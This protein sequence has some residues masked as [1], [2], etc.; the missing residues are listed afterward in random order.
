[1]SS[2]KIKIAMQAGIQG[3]NLG[4]PHSYQCPLKPTML[5]IIR[6][7]ACGLIMILNIRGGAPSYFE[8][9]AN[10][11]TSAVGPYTEGMI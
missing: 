2:I 11:F 6:I 5:E 4:T 1:M 3:L 7:I 10:G 8:V 9:Y